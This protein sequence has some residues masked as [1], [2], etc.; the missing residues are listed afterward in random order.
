MAEVSQVSSDLF[1]LEGLADFK[2]FA[3][4]TVTQSKRTIYLLSNELDLP[5][6]GTDE[7]VGALSAF[8]RSSRYAQVQL[9][10]KNTKLVAEIGH[11]LAKLHQRLPSKIQLRKLTLEPS[12]NDM[13]FLMGDAQFLLY[14]NDDLFFK[15]FAN[16]SAAVEC[17]SLKEEFERLWQ[18][19]ESEPDLQVLHI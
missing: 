13:A 8:A 19:A 17:K 7:F 11:P 9:L 18:W 10:I 16:W 4:D 5:V 14:K 1:L 15:G 6:Y 2:Q 12:D 3:L